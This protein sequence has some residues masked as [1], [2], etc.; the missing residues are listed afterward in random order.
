MHVHRGYHTRWI[1]S[2]LGGSESPPM[3]G[4]SGLT[5]GAVQCCLQTFI[6]SS[7]AINHSTISDHVRDRMTAGGAHFNL[8][9]SC[10]CLAAIREPSL[11]QL[12]FRDRDTALFRR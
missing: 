4:R 1:G 7:D 2:K 10:K 12:P 9:H 6:R 8:R 5:A 11:P 3:I